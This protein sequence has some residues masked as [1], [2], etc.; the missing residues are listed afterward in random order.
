M[1]N[2][3]LAGIFGAAF[4]GIYLDASL[5]R[6]QPEVLDAGGSVVSGGGFADA[7]PVKA[8]ADRVT[9]AMRQQEGFTEGDARILVL[10]SGVAR[11]TTDDEIAVDGTRYKIAFVDTD[12]ANAYWE[13]RGR[14]NG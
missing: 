13:L 8:Q 11:P 2:G 4:G 12:P 14:P 6:A 1:L 9:E 10:A 3:G 7:E 5:Y